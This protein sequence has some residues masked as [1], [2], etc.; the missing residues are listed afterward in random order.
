[1]F[2]FAR[3]VIFSVNDNVERKQNKRRCTRSPYFVTRA[4][5]RA[6]GNGE[7]EKKRRKKKRRKRKIYA[8]TTSGDDLRAQIDRNTFAMRSYASSMSR[9]R[10]E[11]KEKRK[12]KKKMAMFI[13]CRRKSSLRKVQISSATIFDDNDVF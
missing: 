1:M 11:K 13:T 7:K 3:R 8:R 10:K 4:R 9:G 5:A 12:A 6:H 2:T